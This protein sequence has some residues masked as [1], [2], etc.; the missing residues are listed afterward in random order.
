M[1]P[2]LRVLAVVA[3]GLPIALVACGGSTA[4][5][6][7]THDGGPADAGP[8]PDDAGGALPI[9]ADA[10]LTFRVAGGF[11]ANGRDTSVCTVVDETYTL[12]VATG[13]FTSKSCVIEDGG[14]R[15]LYTA[16]S[17]TLS[18]TEA[19]PLRA[20]LAAV[21]IVPNP[22]SCAADKPSERLEV[23]SPAAPAPAVY[24]DQWDRCSDGSVVHVAGLDS[25]YSELVK[26]AR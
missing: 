14:A 24:Y 17:K 22:S 10:T 2:S 16:G 19:A 8:V 20:A 23:S 12:A 11:A 5:V 6:T 18:A 15:N 7:E 21:R 4:F 26:L 9:P 3:L 13:A 25:V 1:R